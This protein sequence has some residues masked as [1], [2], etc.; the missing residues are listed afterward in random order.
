MWL[1]RRK[2]LQGLSTFGL[3]FTSP[4][5]GTVAAPKWEHGTSTVLYALCSALS[6]LPIEEC[7]AI[8]RSVA[9]NEIP[10][11]TLNL[12]DSKSLIELQGSLEILTDTW[13]A[14]IR[15][16]FAKGNT[17]VVRNW[18]LSES[19]TVLYAHLAAAS[20]LY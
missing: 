19:E 12:A 1:N 6:P 14:K 17:L 20:K 4:G 8:G 10:D 3:I 7:L 18:L 16:D 11:V 13:E 15:Q 2:F 9:A 5:P